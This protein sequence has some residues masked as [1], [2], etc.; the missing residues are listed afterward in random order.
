MKENNYLYILTVSYEMNLLYLINSQL[1]ISC[2][3]TTKYIIINKIIFQ[4]KHS[5]VFFDDAFILI[6]DTVE[7]WSEV[8]KGVRAW[9]RP[10]PSLANK[11]DH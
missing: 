1:D 4:T 9:M 10:E 5:L 11:C 3:I 2:Q 8:S 7:E 6:F